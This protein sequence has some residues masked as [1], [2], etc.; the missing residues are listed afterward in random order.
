M[1]RTYYSKTIVN[2][3]RLVLLVIMLE[4]VS[5]VAAWALT[6]G[7]KQPEFQSFEPLGTTGMVNE[8]TGGFTYNL[9]VLEVPR[10]Q[11][12]AYPINLAYHSGSSLEE[13]A[14]WVGAGW[15][16]HPGSIGR[17]VRGFPD[18]HDGVDVEFINKQPA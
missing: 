15:S 17:S 13:D 1:I 10:P 16:L 2:A 12:S 5:P 11:R 3:A 9:P 14:A 4:L 6:N 8:F 7:P 18:D